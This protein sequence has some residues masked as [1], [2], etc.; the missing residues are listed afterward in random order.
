MTITDTAPDT[1]PVAPAD[2]DEAPFGG[3][4]ELV[5]TGAH[6]RIGR[7]F[8]GFSLFYGVVGLV[9]QLLLDLE[10]ITPDEVDVLDVDVL[11]QV[12]TLQRVSLVFLFALPALLGLALVVVPLQVGA[13]TIAFPRAAALSFWTWLVASALLL[14]GY[15]VGG[16]PGGTDLRGTDLW[17]LALGLVVAALVLGAV[18]VVTTVLALRAQG[19]GLRHVPLFSFAMFVAGSVWILTLPVLIGNVVI[20]YLD[21]RYGQVLFGLNANLWPQLAWAVGQPQIYVIAIPVLGIVGDVVPVFAGARQRLY[22]L[23]L[24]GIGLFGVLSIG[25]W[26]QTAFAPDLVTEPLFVAMGVAAIVPV[27]M[28]VALG[29]DTLRAGR[30]RLGAP[31]L[32]GLATWL[33]LLAATAAGALHVI[34]PLELVGTSFGTAQMQLTITAALLGLLAGLWF[35]APKVNGTL[36]PEGAGL[37]LA[38]LGLL[39]G[40]LAGVALA[41]AGVLDQPDTVLP[42]P[43]DDGVDILNIVAVVGTALVLLTLL[44]AAA[45]L[46]RPRRGEAVADDPW[47]GHTLE[48]ATTSPPAPGNFAQPPVVTDERP[49]LRAAT[50]DTADTEEGSA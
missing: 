37:A 48:W 49:L 45:A 50:A 14:A 13:S 9:A 4:G 21:H 17:L 42:G 27:L 32:L 39:G 8:I 29:A 26:A 35:W 36:L 31:L 41:V 34:E 18:T 43:V 6:A 16:G 10:R 20:A 24:A 19:M 3:L 15:L 2:A 5:G 11:G 46:V 1:E 33:M 30:P 47:G 7:M 28:M 12:F 22:D 44:G 38:G 25:A 23:A 40:L